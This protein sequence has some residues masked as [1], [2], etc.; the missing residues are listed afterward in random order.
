MVWRRAER[1]TNDDTLPISAASPLNFLGGTPEVGR[2][3]GDR[4]VADSLWTTVVHST[5]QAIGP[6]EGYEW[7]PRL[8]ADRLD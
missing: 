3:G 1:G 8:S 2:A 4:A 7:R 5:I 6:Y